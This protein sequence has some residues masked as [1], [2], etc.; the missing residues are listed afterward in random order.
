VD[1]LGR[2][3][4][5]TTNPGAELFIDGSA[6]L[7]NTSLVVHHPGGSTGDFSV[8]SPGG[9]V[10]IIASANG[11]N[12]RDVRFTEEGISLLTSNAS[13]IPGSANG[14]LIDEGGNVGIGD[15]TPDARLDVSTNSGPAVW[16]T[17]ADSSG[18]AAVYGLSN[19]D[20]GT[21][22]GVF[23]EAEG[24]N[25][26][27]VYGL[28]SNN[29]GPNFAVRGH[30]NSPDGYA[31][32]FTGGQNYFSGSVGIGDT[33]PDA[34]LDVEAGN[35]AAIIARSGASGGTSGTVWAINVDTISNGVAVKGD[36]E[37]PR[38]HG[39][40]GWAKTQS[41]TNYGVFG[42]T[43]SDD[44]FAVYSLGGKNYFEGN[45]QIGGPDT[46][47]PDNTLDVFGNIR[48]SAVPAGSGDNLV[49]DQQGVFRQVVSSRRYKEAIQPLDTA[50]F[51]EAVLALQPVTYR[52]IES[53]QQDIGLI[54]EDVAELVPGLVTYDAEGRPNAVRYDRGFLYLL[55]IIRDQRDE[56]KR[57]QE[58][59]DG[60]LARLRR[61]DGSQ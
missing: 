35:E 26:R 13:T 24:T 28:A 27:G 47:D 44:G 3:G 54:A 50:E 16:G 9:S 39:V 30:T 6:S 41:G 53:G 31:A 18:V 14:I 12:R 19:A 15:A 4:I 20:T 10:G 43:S 34:A 45:V 42:R 36:A 21:S 59:I 48:V 52:Y 49:V 51:S 57:S 46:A 29:A 56:L 33:T 60:I 58:A 38:G 2:V 5:G 23:G 37:G 25:G 7:T 22:F 17:T 61:L 40:Y 55:E 32:W 1:N 11:G 8:S